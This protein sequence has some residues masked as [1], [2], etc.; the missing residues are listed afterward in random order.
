LVAAQCAA[1]HRAVGACLFEG[2]FHRGDQCG[3]CAGFDEDGEVLPAQGGD[4]LGEP[5]WLP[6]V[7][8]PVVGADRAG[9]PVC[10]HGRVPG[11]GGGGGLDVFEG[12]GELVFDGVD[13]GGVGGVVDRDHAGVRALGLEGGLGLFQRGD[14]SAEDER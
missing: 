6:Q 12:V 1:D 2:F 3:V 5:Y 11:D 7:L 14:W 9:D 13:L 8:V 10:L 4:G